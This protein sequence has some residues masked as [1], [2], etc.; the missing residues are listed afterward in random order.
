[1]RVA[2][3][4]ATG[5]VGREMLRTLDERD[6]PADEVVPLASSRSE[7]VRLPYRGRELVVGAVGEGAFDGVDVAL[8]SAGARASKEWA[9]RAVDAGATVVDNS[10]AFRMDPDV[11]LVIPEI[12]AE[13]M[14]GKV[15]NLPKRE[16]IKL[17][18]QEQLIVELYSR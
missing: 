17:P 11:P 7:G 3:L 6:F 12:N 4:G 2:V 14:T 16:D 8:F 18:I 1:M 10:S 13:A 15:L 9:P 5:A